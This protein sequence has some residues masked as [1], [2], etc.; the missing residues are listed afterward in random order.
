MFVN[1]FGETF[2]QAIAAR[3]EPVPQAANQSYRQ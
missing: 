3:A 2:P 1:Y